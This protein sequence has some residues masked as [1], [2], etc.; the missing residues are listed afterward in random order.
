MD[1]ILTNESIAASSEMPSF[2][3]KCNVCCQE[4]ELKGT[5]YGVYCSSCHHISG[6]DNTYGD[7]ARMRREYLGLTRRELGV[8]LKVKTSSLRRYEHGMFPMAHFKKLE[9]L[10]CQKRVEKQNKT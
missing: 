1:C 2:K 4:T 6:P 8:I 10:I 5:W 7:V 9:E 3:G